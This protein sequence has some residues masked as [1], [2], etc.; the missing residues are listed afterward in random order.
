MTQ[1]VSYKEQS[2][3][4]LVVDTIYEGEAG[5]NI[6]GGS[7]QNLL[8]CANAGRFRAVGRGDKK[9]VVFYTSGE[10]KKWPDEFNFS[11]GQFVY[12]S[13]NKK[14]RGELHNTKLGGNKILRRVFDL[15]H[16]LLPERKSIPLLFVFEKHPTA[17]SAQSVRFRGL[18]VP[19]S[20]HVPA[21]SDLVAGWSSSQDGRFQNDTI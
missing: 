7:I 8:G 20:E 12:Y 10:D 16:S 14:A 3:Y 4:D 15:L 17:T 11:I 21:F 9:F 19:G 5:G 2:A 13:D 18:A 6:S 1:I